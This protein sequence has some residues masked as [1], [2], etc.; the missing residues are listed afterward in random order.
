MLA[1]DG[2]V[3]VLPGS[4]K[5]RVQRPGWLFGPYGADERAAMGDFT[6]EQQAQRLSGLPLDVP[7]GCVKPVLAAGDVLLMPEATL[8][9]VMPWTTSGRRR[10]TFL[11]RYTEQGGITWNGKEAGERK[12]PPSWTSKL[13][14][15]TLALM[16]HGD[17]GIESVAEMSA[18][19]IIAKIRARRYEEQHSPRL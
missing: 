13:G 2:G 12:P 16:G 10:R 7:D 11:L 14:W 8:H 5:A 18:S 4:H 17:V 6:P 15:P 19:E 3:F 1:G 9:G